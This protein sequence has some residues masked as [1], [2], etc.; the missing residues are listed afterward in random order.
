MNTRV[1]LHISG[2]VQGVFF[3]DS[4][5]QM[6]TAMELTG[7]VRNLPDGR[8]EIVAEGEKECVEKLVQWSH[9]GPPWA[10]VEYVERRDEPYKGEFQFFEIRRQER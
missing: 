6:A 5:A 2:K 3:R 4:T 1:H 10:V 9:S 8:V 7:F